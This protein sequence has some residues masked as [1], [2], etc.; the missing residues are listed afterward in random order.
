MINELAQSNNIIPAVK[1]QGSITH[2]ISILQDYDLIVDP[3]SL[4][5]IKE[6][7]NYCWLERKSNTPADNHNHAIDAIRYAVTYQLDNPTR[8]Q[9]FIS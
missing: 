9:Y 3:E 7:N 6:L 5:L 2:G 4:E 1:G 8:G